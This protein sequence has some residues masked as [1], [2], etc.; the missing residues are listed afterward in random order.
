MEIIINYLHQGLAAIIP[1]IILLGLL[2]FVHELGH[3]MVAK[4]F[5]VRV[6]VFS[7][8]FGK[9]ILQYKRGDTNYCL[10]LIPLGGYVK[11][12]GDEVGA[13]LAE[14]EKQFSFLNKPVY[15][16]IGI[17]LAGPLMN[18]F[19]AIFIFFTVA[20][21]GEEVRGPVLGDIKQ[22]TPAY[23]AGFR[24]GDKI[25]SVA[26]ESTKTW[27]E[28]QRQLTSGY[29]KSVPVEVER[30]VGKVIETLSITPALQPNPNILS[31]ESFVGDVPGLSPLSQQAVIGV[32]GN[33]VAEKSGL[34][35]G[36]RILAVNNV[37]IH[38]FR[39]LENIFISQ[40]GEKITLDIERQVNNS[41]KFEKLKINFSK[42][43]YPSL[44]SM[45]IES[46]ELYLSKVSDNS[47]AMQAGLFPGD[48]IVSV[49][50]VIP[51]VWDDL[52]V[53]IKS[54]SGT[55]PLEFNINRRGELKTLNITPQMTTHMTVQGTEEKRFT[56]GIMPTIYISQPAT[57]IVKADGAWP[58][59]LRGYE[60]TIDVTV[61][62][63]MSFVKLIQNKI[64]PKNIGGVI[65]IG[66]AASETFKIGIVHFLQMMA[67]IS[68]N[69]FILNLLPIPILDGGH[70]LFYTI[71]AIRGAPVSMRK[72]EVAQQVG[73][74]LLMSLMIFAL[75]ND[76]SRLL[77]SW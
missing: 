64:S 5:G 60:K 56:I 27:D 55:G 35:T 31:T 32:V 53:T 16:R 23:T 49:G 26:G 44:E 40:Q 47:P 24:S 42:G 66:Q 67:I 54:Y 72:M 45:G 14:E 51:K 29:G 25:L 33:S 73:L 4:F 39:Q 21:I 22:D 38:F 70:L 17:V 43:S 69:L 50:N 11:M 71:E 58:A 59:L 77:G 19:F 52:L 7:L 76:F 63:I 13:K 74:V 41:E 20:L 10:S 65:S 3:F 62:T 18:F 9:K 15:Q 12:F 28:F 36:D 57:T 30:E 37:A 46:A 61:M 1:F 8:G 48:R 68:V 6:E 2:I 34:Q 75:F